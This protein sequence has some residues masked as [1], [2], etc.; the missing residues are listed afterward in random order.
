MLKKIGFYIVFLLVIS[1]CVFS[2]DQDIFTAVQ[3][4][5]IE[6]VISLI[7][8]NPH[9][10]N[11][12]T[13]IGDTPLH[14]ATLHERPEIAK[15]LIKKGADV[16][17]ATHYGYTPLHRAFMIKNLDLAGLLLK[18]GAN[19]N[20]QSSSG[21]APIFLAAWAGHMKGVQ[22]LIQQKADINLQNYRGESP[23]HAAVVGGHRGLAALLETK[24]AKGS[25]PITNFGYFPFDK[26]KQENREAVIWYLGHSGW[27]VKT[28]NHLLV[29][30]FYEG[31]PEPA[32]PKLVNGRINPEE[33]KNLKVIVF[34]S[35]VHGDHF[36][37]TILDWKD[38]LQD[39]R[40]VFG[41]KAFKDP[42]YTYMGFRKKIKLD[43]LTIESIHSPEAGEIE[44]NFLV[45]VDGLT[46]YHSGDYSR[47]HAAFKKDM[48]Y[49]AQ[50]A[51]GIDLFFMLAGSDMDNSEALIA[52]EKV[53]P[54]N[55]FPMHAG[56][57][58]YIFLKFAELAR[59]KG[60]KTK[61][62]CSQNRGDM[63]VYRNSGIRPV[64]SYKE[65]LED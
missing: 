39:I 61:I 57:S 21:T 52:L 56:G 31:K 33:I 16:N 36:D 18:N 7:E 27:A 14:L 40:Y 9:L 20:C 58:E 3:K 8:K 17:A 30:D 24:G 19:I 13:S 46:I 44:G 65:I 51:P 64:D 15:F 53:K 35:H 63:F 47:S 28:K 41:W 4:G 42:A 10:I 29:F 45:R 59:K 11:A 43:K 23:L 26:L 12:K 55:M 50:I 54:R 48:D 1:V 2:L 32:E 25:S 34:V 49:L 5:D 38:K 6:T 60:I 62:I 22:F 37:K